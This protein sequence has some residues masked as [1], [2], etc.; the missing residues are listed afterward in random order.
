VKKIHHSTN[1]HTYGRL[2]DQ[3]CSKLKTHLFS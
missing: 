1:V 3:L 2:A